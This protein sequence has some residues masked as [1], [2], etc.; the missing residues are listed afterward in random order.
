MP[1]VRGNMIRCDT[2]PRCY[3]PYPGKL[4]PFGN[5]FCICG[6][7]GNMVYTTPRKE[8]RISGHGW[9]HYGVSS[10][11][12]FKS[13]EE[14]LARMTEPEKKRYYERAGKSPNEEKL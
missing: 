7:T 11:G 13:V 12:L 14:V 9:I 8:K 10:C 4:D 6:M 5:H 1:E 2:C 3:D